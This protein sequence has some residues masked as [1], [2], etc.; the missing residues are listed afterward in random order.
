[1]QK[2]EPREPCGGECRSIATER[3]RY[4][5]GKYM[6]AR[7]FAV[8]QEYF[9]SRHRLHTRLLHGW[10]V[11]CGLGVTLHPDEEC[12]GWVIVGPGIAIDCCGR[13]LILKE[14]TPFRVDIPEA[15]PHDEGDEGDGGE[16]GS[17]D[18][19]DEDSEYPVDSD[20]YELKKQQKEHE[21]K[22]GHGPEKRPKP[23]PGYVL[24]AVYCEDEVEQVPVIYDDCDCD[25]Q[26][27]EAN[28]VRESLRLELRPVADMDP[29]CWGMPGGGDT[30]C[31]DDC[32][33]DLP[34]AGGGCIDPECIC[35]GC[36]PLA[37]VWRRKD[38]RLAVDT[39]GRRRL[40]PPP[41]MLTHVVQTSWVHGDTVPIDELAD[42]P[43]LELRFDRKLADAEGFATGINS[44]TLLV[45]H[46]G[47]GDD[48][49]FVPYDLDR[50]PTLVDGCRAVYRIDPDFL[51]G[52]RRGGLVGS[53][54]YVTLL[55]NFVLDC[56]DL[57]VDGDHLGGRLPSGDGTP[58]GT[59]HSWFRIGDR[60]YEE[61]EAS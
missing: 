35:G 23:T 55:A 10:G 30:R 21:E 32:D 34:A 12:D 19:D 54:I 37:L 14:R 41:H 51:N 6:T 27:K 26:R 61:E 2:N 1:M 49:E 53:T 24:C 13:E 57:P 11:A 22:E 46:A 45:Q 56:H 16:G 8:E 9:L 15:E 60:R 42:R 17:E 20:E 47:E 43:V 31:R 28:R 58:G 25:A 44:E 39:R 59:F 29:G 50:P 18:H 40:P 48:L 5:T 38:G 36:V 33:D 3:N 7:D 4:F 52:R